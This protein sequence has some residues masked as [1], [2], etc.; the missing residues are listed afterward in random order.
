[1]FNVA[2]VVTLLALF[3]GEAVAKRGCRQCKGT[4]HAV[5]TGYAGESE[6]LA[7]F[8][9]SLGKCATGGDY[10]ILD[11]VPKS[12]VDPCPESIRR[13]KNCVNRGTDMCMEYILYYTVWRFCGNGPSVFINRGNHCSAGLCSSTDIL[14]L[15]CNLSVGC[16][17][18]C[19]CK[20]CACGL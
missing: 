14:S 17:E 6:A 10:E 5:F 11:I 15:T 19:D 3:S 20:K 4:H 9:N 13:E 16:N 12:C 8:R 7:F 1:M 2:Q 18:E